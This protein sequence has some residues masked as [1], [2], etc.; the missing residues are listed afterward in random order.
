MRT[1][2]YPLAVLAAVAALLAAAAAPQAANAAGP[3]VVDSSLR[4]S[5]VIT[6]GQFRSYVT[7]VS[8]TQARVT[9]S[10]IINASSD[11][12]GIFEV[13]GCTRQRYTPC[14]DA[15][16]RRAFQFRRGRNKIRWRMTLNA[17]AALFTVSS[18]LSDVREPAASAYATH[19][20]ID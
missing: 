4:Q 5:Q 2:L 9:V 14:Q 6:G 18:A 13:Y 8:S 7:M 3:W 19:V 20:I 12:S 10:A 1:L 16:D 15:S 17:H 11:G